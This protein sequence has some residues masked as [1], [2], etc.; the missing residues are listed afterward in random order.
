MARQF[1]V[2]H[3]ALKFELLHL[4]CAILSSNY[5]V[6][7]N[8][9]SVVCSRMPYNKCIFSFFSSRKWVFFILHVD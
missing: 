7:S 5:S 9:F 8:L 6:C 2:L 4:L 3:N 1:A